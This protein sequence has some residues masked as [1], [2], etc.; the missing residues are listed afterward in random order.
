MII[1]HKINYLDLIQKI[2]IINLP[3]EESIPEKKWLNIVIIVLVKLLF[4]LL[5]KIIILTKFY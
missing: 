3:T 4:T 2:K 1:K 5:L